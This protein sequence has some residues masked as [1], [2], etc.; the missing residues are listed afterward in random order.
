MSTS[1]VGFIVDAESTAFHRCRAA[2]PL[3]KYFTLNECPASRVINIQSA[4]IGYSER[5]NPTAKPPQCPLR[6]CTRS[7]DE[8]ARLCN[9]HRG[10]RISQKILIFP[11]GGVLALCSLQRDGN[12]I[13]IKYTC[14]TGMILLYFCI[15]LY[16]VACK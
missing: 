5:Y 12:Y 1:I 8:P 4:E 9:G 7:T 14:V 11:R 10:C 13:R 6:N 2:E 15:L 16:C 3:G